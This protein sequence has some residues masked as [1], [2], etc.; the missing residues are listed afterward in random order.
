MDGPTHARR[1]DAGAPASR[2]SARTP[3]AAAPAIV[4]RQPAWT[5]ATAPVSGS[6]SRTGTQSATDTQAA[7][8]GVRV[9]TTSAS[10]AGAAGPSARTARA[11]CT[12]RTR[13]NRSPVSRSR[14]AQFSATAAGSSPTWPPRFRLANAPDDAP[15]LR[16][17]KPC[18]NA[19]SSWPWKIA[20]VPGYNRTPPMLRYVRRSIGRKLMLAL[21][22]PSLLFALVGVLWLRHQTRLL[23]PGLEAVF[24]T[25]IVALVLFSVAMAVTHVVVVRVLVRNPLKRLV[26]ALQRA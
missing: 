24:R 6:A 23:S 14:R 4:P 11:P 26:A 10:T 16:V 1:R 22:A 17:V 7:T 9:T 2:A 25:A 20:I 8:P 13:A 12:W 21:G 5:A 15:P 18:G 19:A 3:S